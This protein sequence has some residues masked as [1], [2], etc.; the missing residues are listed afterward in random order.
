MRGKIRNEEYAKQLMDFSGL[1]WGTITPTNIDF[2]IEYKNRCFIIGEGKFGE[3]ELKGGQKLAL[4]RLCDSLQKSGKQTLLIEYTHR[5]KT[6][7]QIDVEKALVKKFRYAGKWINENCEVK[8][9]IDRFIDKYGNS[10]G[11][12]VNRHLFS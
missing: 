9:L 8:K 10:G 7:E 1:K 4:E 5:C 2:L 6:D 12:K 11:V 3:K